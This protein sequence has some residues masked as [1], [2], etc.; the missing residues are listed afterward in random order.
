MRCLDSITNSI[1]MNLSKLQ[2]A[3]KESGPGLLQ[4]T[5]SQSS[6]RLSDW[7][8][9]SSWKDWLKNLPLH[10]L[11]QNSLSAKVVTKEVF[12]KNSHSA[13]GLKMF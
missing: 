7:T 3:A 12:V 9:G 6:T 1:N 5:G 10:L 2:E 13:V 11:I 8:T 4:S